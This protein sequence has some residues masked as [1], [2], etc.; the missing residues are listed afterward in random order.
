MKFKRWIAILMAL[1]MMMSVVSPTAFAEGWG[2]NSSPIVVNGDAGDGDG[3]GGT[4]EPSECTCTAP[5]TAESK[6]EQC[7]VCTA[8]YTQCKGE[9]S[10]PAE[11]IDLAVG[12]EPMQLYAEYDDSVDITVSGSLSG[13]G[14]ESVTVAIT[15]SDAEA[16]LLIGLENN[17]DFTLTDDD[18]SDGVQ[19]LF[20]TVTAGES[21]DKTL[22]ASAP[23]ATQPTV[24]DVASK[25]VTATATSAEGNAAPMV[26]VSFNEGATAASTLTFVEKLPDAD[27]PYGSVTES[28]GSVDEL[29][30]TYVDKDGQPIARQETAPTFTLWYQVGDAEAVEVDEENPPFGLTQLP[31]ITAASADTTWT[32][33]VAKDTALP[34]PS[35][36][37]VALEGDTVVEKTISWF[38]KPSY[39]E[40]YYPN[41]GTLVQITEDN[42]ETYPNL[43][44]GQWVFIAG[45]TPYED[46]DITITEKTSLSHNIYWADN[47]NAEN[48]RPTLENVSTLYKLQFSLDGSSTYETLTEEN[49][50]SLGLTKMPTPE[51]NVQTGIWSLHWKDTLPSKVTYSDSTGGGEPITRDVTWRYVPKDALDNS[52]AMVEV[53]E[54]NADDYSSVQDRY[55]TYYVLETNLTFTARIYRGDNKEPS[56]SDAFYEQFYLDAEYTGNNHQYFQMQYIKDDNHIQSVPSEDPNIIT[57]TITHLWR[58]NLDNTRINY[59][60]KEGIVETPGSNTVTEGDGKLDNITGLDDPD[61]YFAIS[62]DNSAVPSFSGVTDGVYSGGTLKLTLTGTREFEA[63]KVWLD[64]GRTERPKAVMELWRYREGEAYSTAALVRD[65]NGQPYTVRLTGDHDTET[66]DFSELTQE[67]PLPKYDAEGYRYL[68][69]VREYLEGD[70]ASKYEQVFGKVDNNGSVTDTLPEGMENREAGNT[71]LYNGGTLSN[72][73]KGTIPVTVTKEW[74]A[75]SFQS[76][77][78][79]VMV[80]LRLQSRP[81]NSTDEKD[82]KD[83]KYTYEMTDFYAENLTVT[84]TGAYPQYDEHGQELEY[85]WVEEAVYQGGTVGADG[86]Y[87]GGTKVNSTE[88]GDTRT[89]TLIQ[90]DRDIVYKSTVDA[91][92]TK[93]TNSIANTIDYEVTKTFEG[94]WNAEKYQT[95]YTFA[96]YRSTSGSELKKYAIFTMTQDG[97]KLEVTKEQGIDDAELSITSQGDWIVKISGLPEFDADGQQYEYLLMEVDGNLVDSTTTRDHDGNY[98]SIITNGPGSTNIILV[99]KAW[100]DESDI[101][102]RLPVTITVYDRQTNQPLQINGQVVSTTLGGTNGNWYDLVNIGEKT[103]NEV[104][105]LETKVGEDVYVNNDLDGDGVVPEP[106]YTNNQEG[107][108]PTAVQFKTQYHN[109]EATYAKEFYPVNDDKKIP[110]FTVTNRRLGNINL[111]VKKNW[112]DGDGTARSTLQQAL[113]DADL[114]LAVKLDF[115]NGDNNGNYTI[116]RT[117]Y[118]T[119]DGDTVTISEGNATPIKDNTGASVDAIQNLDTTQSEQTIYFWNLPKYDTNGASVRYTVKEIFV[120]ADGTE[121]SESKLSAD[122]ASDQ[123][124]AVAAAYRDY[125]SSVKAGPYEVSDDHALDTQD[126]TLSNKLSATKDVSWYALWLDDFAYSEGTRPDIYLNIYARK[127]VKDADGNASTTTEW[128]IRDY[129]WTYDESEGS[130]SDGDYINEKTFWKCT[131]E[132][133]PKYDDLGYEIEYFAVMNSQVDAGD[134]DYL[135]TA[136]ASGRD[137]VG[138][139]GIFGTATKVEAPQQ[140]PVENVAEDGEALYA[141]QSGNTF[142]NTIY[143]NIGYSG[144]KLWQ[145]LPDNYPLVD[146]PTVTF[147]LKQWVKG[148]TDDSPKDVATMTINADDWQNLNVNGHYIFAFAHTGENEPASSIDKVTLP[149]GETWLPRFDDYGRLYTY[150]IEESI[151]W[152]GTDAQEN[153]GNGIFVSGPDST[154][155]TFTNSYNKKGNAQLSAKKYLTVAKGLEEYPAIT[156]TLSR[157]YT[158]NNNNGISEPETVKTIT[159]SAADVKQAVDAASGTGEVTVEHEFIFDDLPIYAPNGSEYVY[160]ITEDKKELGGYDTWAAADDPGA[161]ALKNGTDYAGKTEVRALTANN[162]KDSNDKKTI[163]ASF[164]NAPDA[165][166]QGEISLTGTKVWNDLN[167]AFGFRPENLTINLERRANAQS[168]QD[169]AIDWEPVIID[170]TTV[171]ITWDKTT[172]SDQWT[173]TIEDLDRYAETGMPWIYRVTET[174]PTHYTALNGGVATQQ[175]QDAATGEVT[176]NNLTNSIL[177]ST[178]FKKTWVNSDGEPITEDILGSGIELKVG[179]QLQ[180]RAKDSADATWQNA[181]AFFANNLDVN[182]SSGLKGRTYCG[183]IRAALG[184]SK[185][186]SS[187]YGPG[188]SFKNLPKMIPDKDKPDDTITLEYRVVETGVSVYR[189]DEKLLTQTYEV[190]EEG[191]GRYSYTV[192]AGPFSPWY[193]SEAATSQPNSTKEH[194]NKLSTQSLTVKK[195]WD[196]NDNEGYV[197]RPTASVTRYNWEVTFV[198]ERS[199]NQGNTWEEIPTGAEITLHGTNEQ[200]KVS[201]TIDNLPTYAIGDGGSLVTYQYRVRELQ[202]QDFATS[203]D[204]N[205]LNENGTFHGSYMVHYTKE[206]DGTLVVTNTLN[207]ID[208]DAEKVWNDGGDTDHRPAVTLELKYLKAGG[209]A[210]N[211]EDYLSFKPSAQVTLDGTADEDTTS[212]YYE[213]GAWTAT[214]TKV[215]KVVPGS[216]DENGQT[217]YKIF[218]TVTGDYMSTSTTNGTTTTITNTPTVTPSVTKHW[219]GIDEAA[220]VTVELHQIDQNGN[221]ELV[222]TVTLNESNNWKDDFASQPKYDDEGYEYIYSVVE[223]LIDGEDAETAATNDGYGIAYGGDAENGFHVYNHETDVF[224]V[225]KEWADAGDTSQRP[226]ELTVTLERTTV[227][228]PA[229]GDWVEVATTDVWATTGNNCWTATFG[230]QPIADENGVSYTYRVREPEVNGYE[231]TG[232]T[233]AITAE[234][235]AIFRLHNVRSETINIPVEKM[236]EDSNDNFDH[237]PGSITVELYADGVATGKT[238]E[239]KPT[240]LENLLNVFTSGNAGWSGKFENLPKFNSDGEL[241]TY[242]VKEVVDPNSNWEQYYSISYGEKDDGTQV[243]T[244][245]AHGRL[246]VS[247]TVEGDGG[248]PEKAF[249]FTVTLSDDTING[250]Y[251]KMK[252]VKGTATFTL[253]HGQTCIAEGLPAGLTY[254]VTETDANT[255]AYVTT[256]TGETDGTIPASDTAVAAFTNTADTIDIPVE[257]VWKDNDRE[258]LRPAEITV[259]LLADGEDTGKTLTLNAKN[260]WKGSFKDLDVTKDG[261]AITYTIEEAEV[262]GYRT[263]ITGDAATGFTITNTYPTTPPPTPGDETVDVSG[264]KT[265]SDSDNQDGKRPESITIRLYA[266]G[267]EVAHKAVTAADNWHWD[268]SDL[269]RYEDGKEIVYTITEDPVEGYTSTVNGYDVTNTYDAETVDVSGDKTWND[270]DNQDGKRPESITIRLYANGVE[271][272]HKVVTAAD[273]WHWDFSDLPKYEDGKEIVYTITEDAIDGYTSMVSGSDVTNAYTP[274]KTTVSVTKSWQDKNDQ[275]GKRPD[276][277]TVKLFANGVDTGKTL[278]LSKDNNWTASFGDLDVYKDGQRITYTIEEV[279]VDGYTTTI[280]GDAV[281]GFVITNSITTDTTP[282]KEDPPSTSNPGTPSTGDTSHLN[283]WLALMAIAAAGMA[284]SVA[285]LRRRRNDKD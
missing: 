113:D 225:V 273:N 269:P 219:L 78:G 48:K 234:D 20:F 258:Y 7:T 80:K 8:D 278:T 66:V 27:N 217:V 216:E 84:H 112:V 125:S 241:I 165:S 221:D 277:I 239:L 122:G 9:Q 178:S 52:Y 79:D 15:L 205:K 19:T 60:L 172:N 191:S 86:K 184:D 12:W 123:Y 150:E 148:Y 189:N 130:G 83:T 222:G 32:G 252:F 157:T 220:S 257:K 117:G 49:M 149:D 13:T 190:R 260:G 255:G 107:K 168:G 230:K 45:E 115:L 229:E 141:L 25:D 88:N 111:T 169:N 276:S 268:F 109:Y 102:H 36:V 35:K 85:R 206:D 180:V 17:A 237:R 153:Q 177:T 186:N 53:T 67:N 120:D 47:G 256:V 179:Y 161:D 231:S 248:D 223:T 44:V 6:N 72:R 103:A 101:Q 154:G 1:V 265:W 118:G 201:E 74:E 135:E 188:D 95:S 183:T 174:K 57:A 2:Q 56:L 34:L 30:V 284:G 156:M 42:K 246:E 54:E 33:S 196:D 159:W 182:D 138:T 24:F 282:P 133:L 247:K 11:E 187:C 208:L 18:P 267:V 202:S 29:T 92:G 131:I 213:D 21:F 262:D 22:T 147:T 58:Y 26:Q 266:N 233:V 105:I 114:N 212:F 127:H 158:K 261:Q 151:D 226:S 197:T 3:D 55:G 73:L 236:W 61:D 211:D 279:T 137:T 240:I 193:G 136:Y 10:Q 116:S 214:W 43:T 51:T 218:E 129:R 37:L 155:Q 244:N 134:F 16:A 139:I 199:A 110:M 98:Q 75:A 259:K 235:V 100:V 280:S 82:W 4:G 76:A 77:F 39:P 146:L 89:F 215:P 104:Y 175:K 167:N 228:N 176:M 108:T 238:L 204:E 192:D 232:S 254:T 243:I 242:T 62:Y 285:L 224:Y 162:N 200:N 96:L 119:P 68:Y 41:A 99:R 263:T 97:T 121:V 283:R 173:Y 166:D 81:V 203:T 40:D 144:E 145:N 194:K 170:G 207:T 271:V 253:T 140:K 250:T 59:S 23:D 132:N 38:L 71:W 209:N 164:L 5:C 124:K 163:D 63:T 50:K 87:S 198:V 227:T 69:V 251:G 272:A 264:D 245:T 70:H 281:T 143:D 65:K 93:I 171:Q 275:A 270:S 160:T 90:N 31:E 94:G 249:E 28:E 126:F 274:D 46:D 142:V 106:V 152:E 128:I 14:A 185:W 181:E 91:T 195:V 210:E 64:D